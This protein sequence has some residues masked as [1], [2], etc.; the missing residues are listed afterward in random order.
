MSRY[1]V[2]FPYA[3]ALLKVAVELNSED[4]VKDDILLI[5]QTFDSQPDI[6]EQLSSP[7]LILEQKLDCLKAAFEKSICELSINL[8]R[9]VA[10]RNRIG[11]ISEI[12]AT[13]IHLYNELHKI[14][15]VKVISAYPVDTETQNY[16]LE[17][18]KILLGTR[19]ILQ[20][21][22]DQD[23][24]SGLKILYKDKMIDLSGIGTLDRFRSQLTSQIAKN[25]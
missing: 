24:L 13:Y 6:L 10:R 23:L 12:C 21:E 19:I 1:K 9:V 15:V 2:A 25:F 3:D 22:I 8:F 14:T 4:R 7:A 17:K 18:L 20:Y 11:Y 5:Q 16:I